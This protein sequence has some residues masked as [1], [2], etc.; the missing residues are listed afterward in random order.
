MSILTNHQNQTCN[1]EEDQD[2][3]MFV[4]DTTLSEVI[5]VGD[6]LGCNFF[7]T[8]QANVDRMVGFLEDEGMKLNCKM[9]MEMIIDFRKNVLPI[10]PV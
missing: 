6:Q 4:G 8:I 5:S 2:V 3:A 1:A 7:G 10:P 9:C